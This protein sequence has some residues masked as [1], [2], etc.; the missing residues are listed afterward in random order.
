MTILNGLGS[1]DK[2]LRV[3][4]HFQTVSNSDSVRR[5]KWSEAC[6]REGIVACI[7]CSYTFSWV[8]S[9]SSFGIFVLTQ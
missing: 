5:R 8:S 3:T 9:N 4:I 2:V 1:V 7:Y 6:K